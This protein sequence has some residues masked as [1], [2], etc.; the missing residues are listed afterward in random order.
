MAGMEMLVPPTA[1]EVGILES[2]FTKPKHVSHLSEYAS[3]R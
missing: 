1:V 2:S 3:V